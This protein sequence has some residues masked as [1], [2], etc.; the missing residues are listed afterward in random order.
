MAA[1]TG[2]MNIFKM[3]WDEDIMKFVGIKRE[4]LPELVDPKDQLSGMDPKLADQI[5]IPADTPFVM[6]ALMVPWLKLV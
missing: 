2:L 3:D 6:G 5:G 1:T 4:Q